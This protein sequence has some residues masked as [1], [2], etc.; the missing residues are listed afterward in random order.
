M[1]KN[2]YGSICITEILEK[3]K[4]KHSAFMKAE[5]GKIYMNV[6]VWLNDEVDKYGNVM[7]LKANPKKEKKDTEKAF[8][9]GNCKEGERKELPVDKNDIAAAADAVEDFKSDLPF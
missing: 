9:I 1:G 5:N 3:M 2:Y 4:E 8:Y 7:A 6:S